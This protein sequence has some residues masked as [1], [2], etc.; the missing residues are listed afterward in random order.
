[1]GFNS[2]KN[3]LN[4]LDPK[5]NNLKKIQNAFLHCYFDRK[6]TDQVFRKLAQSEETDFSRYNY[7]YSIYLIN[8]NRNNLAKELLIFH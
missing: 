1:M 4:K 5:F 3:E 2:S 6:N 8:T 7:F